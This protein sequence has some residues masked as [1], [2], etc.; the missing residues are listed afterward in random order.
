MRTPTTTTVNIALPLVHMAQSQPDT[1]AIALP[2]GCDWPRWTGRTQSYIEWSYNRL[3]M[4]SDMLAHAL[5]S[6]GITHGVRTA[7]MVKPGPEFFALTFAIAKVG[8]VP[9]II[10]P[11]IGL[12]HLKTC[13]AEAEPE[14]FIGI[15]TAQMARMILGWAKH[16]IKTVITA[17]TLSFLSGHS[18]KR[19][20][21]KA[22]KDEFQIVPTRS[23]DTAAII[24]TSGSTGVPK[25]VVYTHGNFMAQIETLRR[26]SGIEPGEIDLPTF[27]IFALFDPALGMASIIPSMDPTKP[28]KANP[29]KIINAL[30]RY[31]VTNMFGSPALLDRVGRYGEQHNIKLPHLRRVVSAGAPVQPIVMKRFLSMLNEEAHILTPY[32]A[33]EALPVCAV[34]SRALLK[35]A[36]QERNRSGAG[37][38]VGE[39]LPE[40]R[41]RI[42]RRTNDNINAWD[43]K[44][45]LPSGEVGEIVVQGDMV[46]HSYYG[47]TA[48]TRLAKIPHPDG[49]MHR[50]GDLGFIDDTGGL[51]FCGRKA[52]CIETKEQILY[53]VPC[54][55]IFNAHPQVYRSALVR[56]HAKHG[57]APALCVQLEPQTPRSMRAKVLKELQALATQFTMTQGI[58]NILFKTDFPVDIRHNAKI[59]REA[60][61]AWAQKKLGT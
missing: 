30:H 15:A 57:V 49:L 48:A 32:G 7:L 24:F 21:A 56:V 1:L 54:E 10:D 23:S 26:I 3:N 55:M 50:M 61:G 35:P 20:R 38:F 53:S 51:W 28:A 16:S 18:L 59:N 39:P 2:V 33:T 52:H 37:V 19:L 17:G 36:I 4:E 44:L 5:V 13:L 22:S 8:A 34:S 42:I 12:K 6:V 43:P 45:E 25:G 29:R 41:L 40:A 31:K 47:R 27:P 11:G 9:V 14:A 60:L 46:T 58:R